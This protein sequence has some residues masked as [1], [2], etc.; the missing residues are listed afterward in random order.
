MT[1]LAK[2]HQKVR[3]PRQDFHHKTALALVQQHDTMYH[4]DL[5]PANM[6][7]HHR[8]AKSISDAG[9]G[10]FLIILTHK[11]ACAGRRVVAVNPAF[12]LTDL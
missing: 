10:A 12:T 5:Q 6:G 2:A 8:L 7:K 9:W 1:L 3:R 11:A 4:E